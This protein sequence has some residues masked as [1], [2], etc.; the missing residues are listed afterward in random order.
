MRLEFSERG[1]DEP[2][3][4]SFAVRTSGWVGGL[5][6]SVG[7]R[8][9]AESLPPAY[10]EAWTSVSAG[11]E[12]R[13]Y[14]SFMPEAELSLPRKEARWRGR[15]WRADPPCLAAAHYAMGATVMARARRAANHV[16]LIFRAG[17]YQRS[18]SCVLSPHVT[19]RL[20][21]HSSL[22]TRAVPL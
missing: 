14:A 13:L 12:P 10:T 21:Y 16:S 19:K 22:G 18:N 7:R 20:G 5:R 6:R 2:V 11:A 9:Q 1:L 8:Q 3:P 4:R 17:R 15:E